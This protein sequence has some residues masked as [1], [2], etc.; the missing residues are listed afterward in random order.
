MRSAALILAAILASAA[1]P[2]AAQSCD[3]NLRNNLADAAALRGLGMAPPLAADTA[4][5]YASAHF[6][7]VDYPE[8]EARV[9]ETNKAMMALVNARTLALQL[10]QIQAELQQ[11]LVLKANRT[12]MA[13]GHMNAVIATQ[14]GG[15]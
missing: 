14:C 7:T 11:T 15:Q 13:V 5:L 1:A 8:L 3:A 12:N 6:D 9:V 10:Q 4:A 2:A